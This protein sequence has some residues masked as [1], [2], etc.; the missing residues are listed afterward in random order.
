MSLYF[1]V[2]LRLSARGAAGLAAAAVVLVAAGAAVAGGGPENVAVIV[3]ADSWAS[4]AVANEFISLR[5][6][7]PGNVVYLREVPEIDQVTVDDFRDRILKPV[8]Q[9]LEE[10]RLAGQID[11]IVYSS[12]FP[13][14]IDV[15]PD[16]KGDG[17]AKLPAPI[18]KVLT[19]TASINGLTY[20][21]ALVLAK[22]ARY[23]DLRSNWYYRRAGRRQG[24]GE[25]KVQRAIAF[26]SS[27]VWG[28]DGLTAPAGKGMRYVLSTMLAVTS[29]RGNSVRQAIACLRRSVS[30]DGT[31]PLGRI[32]YMQ[33]SDVRS[34]VRE[35]M[36][37]AAVAELKSLAV[38]AEVA[39]GVL[40]QG[41]D[42]VAGL[43][44]GA[45]GFNWRSCKSKILPGAICEHFTSWG[46]V[47]SEGAKQTP[48]TE[49]IRHGAAGSCG[50][51]AEPYAISAKFP[52]AFIHVHYARGCSLAEAFYQ[53]V[54]GP[55]QL[56][57]VGDPLC[58]PWARI[59]RVEAKCLGGGEAIKAGST[60]A[61]KVTIAPAAA[62]EG[63][64]IGR[65]ELFVDGA[66]REIRPSG[67]SFEL[68]TTKLAD[69]YHELRVVGVARGEIQTQG[70][71][72]FPLVASNRGA[73]LVVTP[74][75]QKY[76][77]WDKPVIIGAKLDRA[78]RIRFVHNGREVAH[79]DGASGAATIDPR[80][81]GQGRV[82]VQPIGEIAGEGDQAAPVYG[83]PIELEVRPPIPTMPPKAPPGEKL[84]K[85]VL[86]LSSA[87]RK[88][89]AD[90][91]K[92]GW[93]NEAGVREGEGFEI[94]ASLTV[95]EHDVYQFQLKTN[96][97]LVIELNSRRLSGTKPGQWRFI[98]V[99]LAAG[100]HRLRIRGK[101][102][103]K[104]RLEMRFGGPGALNIV[105][106]LK[107]VPVP[108]EIAP[109]QPKK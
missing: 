85:G 8:L 10:R 37:A 55:Y 59:P 3:N 5:Q 90:K 105:N 57:I 84:I 32:Y 50:T 58:Q 78:K 4:K 93:L 52:T 53:S 14:S 60:V 98:P 41:K 79:I 18:R 102:P 67:E 20:L 65:Y 70:R 25:L 91:Y 35:P 49:F 56:L 15:R 83:E 39:Q 100:T 12:D 82:R 7:P 96:M 26:R 36:F 74:P 69:G 23:L 24:G 29:G 76:L 28:A 9:T 22:D 101:A 73:K 86:V 109:P 108:G 42:D 61:G 62:K 104:P 92:A 107:H 17:M 88:T 6:I 87:G 46:G 45:A 72:I 21:Y 47:M 2:R 66:R 34:R 99:S 48:L 77:T 95:G 43:L 68:D 19:P 44:T 33:N 71:T 94:R 63:P 89:V 75:K 27:T 81:L 31:S 106:T 64:Q 80:V 30:A 54:S 40:P 38:A 13:W 97:D 16:T 1:G 103:A 51:V 11:Y